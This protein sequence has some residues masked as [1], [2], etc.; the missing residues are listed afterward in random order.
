VLQRASARRYGECRQAAGLQSGLPDCKAG[1]RPPL[2]RVRAS[3]LQSGLPPAGTEHSGAS[4][5]N[6]RLAQHMILM[7]FAAGS[8]FQAFLGCRERFV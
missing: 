7:S 2:R 1:F 3:G 5:R 6:F 4:I 8:M